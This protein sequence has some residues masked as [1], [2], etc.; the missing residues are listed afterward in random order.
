M[1]SVA[2]MVIGIIL[3]GIALFYLFSGIIMAIF[4]GIFCLIR[5][6]FNGLYHMFNERQINPEYRQ[7]MADKINAERVAKEAQIRKEQ[8]QAQAEA[9]ERLIYSVTKRVNDLR[10]KYPL[11]DKNLFDEFVNTFTTRTIV[12]S[13]AIAEQIKNS[14]EQKLNATNSYNEENKYTVDE[15]LFFDKI[16]EDSYKEVV[17]TIYKKDMDNIIV[18]SNTQTG[19]NIMYVSK[20]P[21]VINQMMVN[22]IQKRRQNDINTLVQKEKQIKNTLSTS[23]VNDLIAY[24]LNTFRGKKG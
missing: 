18:I 10:V 16:K 6:I 1:I 5:S 14:H 21:V 2:L 12:E 24:T 20:N 13:K 17:T 3:I 9:N 8:E 15:V 22:V 11:A 19:S 7:H 4:T 23:D